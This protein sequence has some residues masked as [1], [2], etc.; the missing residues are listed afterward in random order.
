MSLSS[1]DGFQSW[2]HFPDAAEDPGANGIP[3]LLQR[4]AVVHGRWAA[5]AASRMLSRPSIPT[6]QFGCAL[7][8]DPDMHIINT[9]LEKCLVEQPKDCWSSRELCLMVGNFSQMM[10]RNGQLLKDGVPRPWRVRGIGRYQLERSCRAAEDD[11]F[12]AAG[13]SGE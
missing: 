3:G 13:P 8:D 5:K 4:T 1:L 9:I 7:P 12:S 11:H 10:Q 6:I 2:L